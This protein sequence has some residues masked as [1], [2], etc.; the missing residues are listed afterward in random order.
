[1]GGSNQLQKKILLQYVTLNV[2]AYISHVNMFENKR[3]ASD[4]HLYNSSMWDHI[5]S[6]IVVVIILI[7]DISKCQNLYHPF[8][9]RIRQ[10]N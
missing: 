3:T 9:S 7:L 10:L 8:F 6:C 4:L 5:S 2:L 1:M